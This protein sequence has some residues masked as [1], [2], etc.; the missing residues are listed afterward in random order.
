MQSPL[1]TIASALR[2][3]AEINEVSII[4]YTYQN[5]L[6]HRRFKI[7]LSICP[8]KLQ[9]YQNLQ[10]GCDTVDFFFSHYIPIVYN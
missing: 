3:E 4:N 5:R 2:T 1:V 8:V 10:S 7:Y 6:Q 9:I